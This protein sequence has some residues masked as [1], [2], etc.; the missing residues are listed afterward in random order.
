MKIDL[1]FPS[2][3]LLPCLNWDCSSKK[4]KE[5][6]IWKVWSGDLAKLLKILFFHLLQIPQKETATDKSQS[7]K[8]LLSIQSYLEDQKRFAEGGSCGRMV[9]IK[10]ARR[11]QIWMLKGQ[12]KKNMINRFFVY[13][14]KRAN[15]RLL[16]TPLPKIIP[17][18]DCTFGTNHRKALIFSGTLTPQMT[19]AK[20][21]PQTTIIQPE[22][23]V[24]NRKGFIGIQI[25]KG[26]VP[27][28]NVQVQMAQ[29]ET[30]QLLHFG[31]KLHMIQLRH[32]DIPLI[33]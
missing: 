4:M 10:C 24:P 33:I 28:P 9:F 8:S 14:T 31:R 19:L 17:S 1:A 30:H 25:P 27:C 7:T 13:R 12:S 11:S 2:P 32:L 6:Q 5:K 16:L 29:E 22:V 18:E 21:A 3:S 15:T 20:R 26:A 23:G